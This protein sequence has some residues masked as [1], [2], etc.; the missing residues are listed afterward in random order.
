MAEVSDP[1]HW[2]DTAAA[3]EYVGMTERQI[4]RAR[5]S[6]HLGCTRLGGNRALHSIEQLEAYIE[7]C[8]EG[9]KSAGDE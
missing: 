1:K 7:R 5:T 9:P 6:G 3:A 2:L 4:R 8:V